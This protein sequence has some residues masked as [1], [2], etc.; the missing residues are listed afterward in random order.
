LISY[1]RSSS[2]FNFGI[3]DDIDH[4]LGRMVML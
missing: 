4:F 3:V 2:R 1:T